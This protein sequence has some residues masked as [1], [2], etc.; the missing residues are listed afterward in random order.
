MWC[1][2]NKDT[3]SASKPSHS[4]RRPVPLAQIEDS[5]N[6]NERLAYLPSV[7]ILTEKNQRKSL[8]SYHLPKNQIMILNYIHTDMGRQCAIRYRQ[9]RAWKCDSHKVL[10]MLSLGQVRT[11]ESPNAQEVYYCPYLFPESGLCNVPHYEADI[12]SFC[13]F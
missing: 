13:W 10:S 6:S 9:L 5:M 1:K 2:R 8:S 3:T 4:H 12:I 7:P 11:S